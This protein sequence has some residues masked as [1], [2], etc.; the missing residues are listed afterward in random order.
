MGHSVQMKKDR[1]PEFEET[2]TTINTLSDDCLIHIF[3]RLTTIADKIK[4]ERGKLNLT[5]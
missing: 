2:P 3:L 4:I 1:N 5:F